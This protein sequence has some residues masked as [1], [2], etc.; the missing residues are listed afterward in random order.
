MNIGIIKVLYKE[1]VN[2]EIKIPDD[3]VLMKIDY[4]TVVGYKN[5]DVY[6]LLIRSK[7]SPNEFDKNISETK[8]K[9]EGYWYTFVSQCYLED[10]TLLKDVDTIFK[11]T[12]IKKTCVDKDLLDELLEELFPLKGE[13]SKSDFKTYELKKVLNG[14]LVSI[15]K[16]LK[17]EYRGVKII[18]VDTGYDTF[19]KKLWN[20]STSVS[21]GFISY[22]TF[23]YIND[24]F[25]FSSSKDKFLGKECESE[26]NELYKNTITKYQ[27]IYGINV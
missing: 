24:G 5:H 25:S 19:N 7:K 26:F 3:S 1:T 8:I 18:T 4:Q 16:L 22:D 15:T 12:Y 14:N 9:L 17:F 6:G 21:E 13:D 2:C 11:E 27:N 23:I 20:D 10:E